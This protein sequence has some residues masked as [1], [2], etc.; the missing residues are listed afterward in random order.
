MKKNLLL[1]VFLLFSGLCTMKAQSGYSVY[2]T[3]TDF[4]LKNLKGQYVSLKDF[5]KVQGIILIFTCNHCPFSKAY[6]DR[7][8]ALHHKYA[9]KGYPVLAINPNDAKAYP[10]DSYENMIVRAREKKFPFEYLYDE[11]QEIARR[12]GAVKTPHVFLLGKVGNDF[13]VR[14]IGAIDDNTDE[15]E[16]VKVRYVEQAIEEI[17]KGQELTFPS[18]KAIGCGIKWKKQ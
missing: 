3:V 8:I 16:L 17:G 9:P 2:S 12:F 11:S 15:P 6:E 1:F 4:S 13:V 14:Y 7:I 10:E 18:T 5:K